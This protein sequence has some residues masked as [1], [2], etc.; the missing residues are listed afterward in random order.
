VL[1]EFVNDQVQGGVTK[2]PVKFASSAMRARFNAGDG[3]LYVSGLKG[4]QTNAGKEGGFDRVRYTGKAV[5]MP[6][7]LNVT[8]KGVKITF[9]GSMDS[10]AARDLQN[11]NCE[12]WNYKWTQDYGSPEISTLPADPAAPAKK[13]AVHDPMTIKSASLVDDGKAVFLE[14]ENM[15]PVMQMKVTFKLKASDGTPVSGDIH[16]TIHNLGK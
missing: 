4:W 2:I 5:N 8:D 11:Y 3:Q 10:E 7:G 16:N 12:V 6:T 15:R 1:K 13:G 14:I 9:T